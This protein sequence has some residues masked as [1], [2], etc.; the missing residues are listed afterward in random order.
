MDTRKMAQALGRRGGRA[1]ARNLT[2]DERRHIAALGGDARRRSL[3]AA[4]RLA[5]NFLY[6]AMVREL[7]PP[8]TVE[9]MKSFSGRLPG[10]YPDRD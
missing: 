9:R 1:R 4:R 3:E 5:A 8:P 2:P 6:A 10:L 7:R